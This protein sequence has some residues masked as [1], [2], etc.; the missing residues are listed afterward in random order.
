MRIDVPAATVLLSGAI[1]GGL[2]MSFALLI[3]LVHRRFFVWEDPRID[4]LSGMLPGANCGAC[5]HPGCRAFAESVVAGRNA[6]AECTVMSPDGVAEVAAY[7]G[8]A[9]G[10]ISRRVARLHCAGGCD[11]APAIAEYRGRLT[12]AAAAAVAGGGKACAWGCLGLA[13]CEVAC[14]FGAIYMNE[15]NLPVVIP[16]KCTAC[17]DCV[18]ACPRD[19][20]ELLPTDARLLVQCRNPVEGPRAEQ[21]CRVACNACGKCALDAPGVITMKGGLP[22]IDYAAVG[23]A[24]PEAV[25]RCPTGAI[26]WLEGRQFTQGPARAPVLTGAAA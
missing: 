15:Q 2:G 25:S 3:A 6:P 14:D 10:K 23:A 26:V 22:V 19:L 1:L 17:G 18:E 4:V 11:V 13:D 9:A 8:V 16:E 21:V 24:G 12:C 7:L 20:F 5:G